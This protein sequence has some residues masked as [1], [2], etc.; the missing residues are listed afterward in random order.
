M[1][2]LKESENI[3]KK[4]LR[5]EPY[6]HVLLWCMVLFYPYIKYMGKEG[7]YAMSIPHE[8][9]SLFFKMTISYFSYLWFFPKENKKKYI[10][11]VVLIY[12]INAVAY[13]YM[14]LLF[15]SEETSFWKNFVANSLT[16]FSFGI[17]FFAVF[18]IKNAYKKQVEIDKLTQEKQQ[19]EIQALKARFNPHFLFNTLNTIYAN[20]LRK[21][22]KTP[23]L[24][25]KLSN[26]FRYVLHEGQKK[27]VTLKQELQHL[28]DYINLQ[29][30]RLI[31]KIVI[32]FSEDINDL[33]QKITPLLLIGFIENAF[34]YTSIL[35]G[36]DHTIKIRIQVKNGLLSFV[37][38]NPFQENLKD[39]IDAEWEESGIGIQNTTDR[40]KL[41]YPERHQLKIEKDKGLFI[42]KLE[43]QL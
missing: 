29:Q 42:I 37:C 12:I 1:T 18:S 22:D 8:L 5:A 13:D 7:G 41:L 20:A 10:S 34:K 25:L 39:N 33:D 4:F 28:K 36:K 6:F 16:Y 3:Y 26:G 19:A 14:D 32:E 15:H 21:D 35:K 24:I 23:D 38:E 40:L 43:I 31:N 30:E 27:H 17:V 11:I 9:N 2:V